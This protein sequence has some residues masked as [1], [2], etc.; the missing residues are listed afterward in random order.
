MDQN[1]VVTAGANSLPPTERE[2]DT[3]PNTADRHISLNSYVSEAES[4]VAATCVRLMM[5]N[6]GY[7]LP[8]HAVIKN[9]SITTKCRV[10]FD[11]SAKSSSGFSLNNVHQ[12]AYDYIKWVFIPASSPSFGGIWEAG[13]KSAKSHIKRVIGETRLTFEEFATVLTQI[14]SIL[15][16]RPLCP[17]T[18]DPDDLAALTPGH[19]LI[20]RPL[21]TLPEINLTDV[22]INR[23]T[24]W[25]HLQMMSQHY[26]NRWQREYLT[27]LQ[28]RVKWKQNSRHLLKV[29]ILV[30]VKNDNA[31]S[32]NW[33][34]GRVTELHPG[35]DGVTRVVSLKVNDGVL[36][37]AVNRVCALP[38]INNKISITT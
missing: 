25:Q 35:K 19:F 33:Q 14:E 22:P 21:T 1:A 23:L 34:L 7:Y 15:N 3:T 27:E 8:Y 24:K 20:R 37:R 38:I 9:C 29:G 28:N 6:D 16:S 31:P 18:Q 36:T 30:L 4:A 11:A 26:W 32:V 2:N 12:L 5:V 13:I 17:L 10:V